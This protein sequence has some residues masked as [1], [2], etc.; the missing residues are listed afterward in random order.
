MCGG[1]G[2]GGGEINMLLY[3]PPIKACHSTLVESS[4]CHLIQGFLISRGLGGNSM[5]NGVT[6]AIAISLNI[7]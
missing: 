3:I 2:G 1:G 4:H 5:T 7:L 6:E